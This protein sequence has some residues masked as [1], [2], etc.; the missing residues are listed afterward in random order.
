MITPIELLDWRTKKTDHQLIDIREAYEV[1]ICSIGGMHIPM[2]EV[3]Q[4]L[5]EIRKDI[6]VVIHCKSGKRSQAVVAHLEK[7]GFKN[8]RSLDGG[9]LAW[10]DQVEPA[11]EKY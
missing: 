9:I 4:R 8:L 3:Q 2:G 1:E 10:I 5:D 7:F 11:L 6:P